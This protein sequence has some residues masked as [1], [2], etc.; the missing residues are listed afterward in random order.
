MRL[1]HR[2]DEA[3]AISREGFRDGSGTYMT[4]SVYTGVWLSDQPL[5]AN[6]GAGGRFLLVVEIPEEVVAPYEWVEEGKG[7]REFLVP[8]NLVNNY[9]PSSIE[10]DEE[11]S[12]LLGE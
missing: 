1:F 12:S 5:D 7:Y 11:G 3:D 2:T 4:S 9:G 6:E 8:A 10:E